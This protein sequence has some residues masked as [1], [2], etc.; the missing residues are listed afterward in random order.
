MSAGEVL[1]PEIIVMPAAPIS[2]AAATAAPEHEVP[3][4]PTT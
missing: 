3:I 4:T 2:G 1:P